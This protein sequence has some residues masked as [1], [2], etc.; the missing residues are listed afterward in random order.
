MI[1]VT[2]LNGKEF[3]LNAA[4]IE[5][6]EAFPDTTITLLNGKKFIVK[7]DEKTVRMLITEYY[8]QIQVLRLIAE[9]EAAENE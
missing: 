5:Q 2:K 7:E 8:Q 1:Y 9:V 3:Q 4:F 6:V